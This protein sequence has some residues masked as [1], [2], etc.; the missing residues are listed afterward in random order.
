MTEAKNRVTLIGIKMA[1]PGEEFIYVGSVPACEGCKVRKACHNLLEGRRYRVETVRP[2]THTCSVFEDGAQ[3]V[4]VI[5]APVVALIA[6]EM[7]I[8][9]SRIVFEYPCNRNDCRS[10]DLCHPEGLNEKERYII[11]QILG[12]APDECLRG[13]KNMKL[14]EL[15]PL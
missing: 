15:L 8:M 6:G 1:K 10:Y 13:R 11:T 4:E 7:A 3:V 12:N 2:T 9:N 14:V 5:E